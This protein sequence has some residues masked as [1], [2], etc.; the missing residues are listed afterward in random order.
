M[1]S[2][3]PTLTLSTTTLIVASWSREQLSRP[4]F[5]DQELVSSVTITSSAE[6]C[7]RRRMENFTCFRCCLG[8]E[9]PDWKRD[10]PAETRYPL[11]FCICIWNSATPASFSIKKGQVDSSFMKLWCE[12]TTGCRSCSCSSW[13]GSS[14][15][16]AILRRNSY[17]TD[18]AHDKDHLYRLFLTAVEQLVWEESRTIGGF[19]RLMRIF[20]LSLSSYFAINWTLQNL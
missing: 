9:G 14:L 2:R 18:S 5:Q 7:K 1:F 10:L 19:S 6:I 16:T 8:Q 12:C 20:C 3:F 13:T 4:S 15:V 17:S 11:P